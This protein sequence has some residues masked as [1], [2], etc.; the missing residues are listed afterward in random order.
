MIYNPKS[1][2]RNNG[3]KTEIINYF[4]QQNYEYKLIETKLDFNPTDIMAQYHNEDYNIIITS[5]GD[6]TVSETI[7]AMHSLNIKLPLL[8]LPTGTTN[9]IAQNL[10]LIEDSITTTLSRLEH[11]KYRAVDYGLIN[12]HDTFTYALTFGNFTEVTYET[13]QGLKNWLGYRAYLLYGFLSFRKIKTYHVHI[14]SKEIDIKDDFV[15]GAI[16][17]SKSM[18]NIIKYEEKCIHLDDGLFEV[19]FIKRPK[20]VKQLRT[21]IHSLINN[22]Y[23]NNMFLTFSTHELQVMSDKNI[24][25]NID[26]EFGGKRKQVTVKNINKGIKLVV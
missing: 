1:G 5:G 10:G 8:I 4:K 16:S 2:L 3:E 24:T 9:E 22:D 21:I 15:F 11:P 17:N 12:N 19:L 18:G 13:P 23:N 26:G 6:G 14:L 25:W 7:Q 20:N